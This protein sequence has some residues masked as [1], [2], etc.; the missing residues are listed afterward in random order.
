M[1]DALFD[2]NRI[3][4]FTISLDFVESGIFPEMIKALGVTIIRAETMYHMAAIEY[5]GISPSFDVVKQGTV[6][7]DYLLVA[8]RDGDEIRYEAKKL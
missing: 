1:T 8:H 3:G 7:P 4:K 5:I 6:P 2:R